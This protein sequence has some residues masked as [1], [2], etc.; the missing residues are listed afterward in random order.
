MSEVGTIGLVGSILAAVVSITVAWITSRL[1]AKVDI[2]DARAKDAETDLAEMKV[3]V[4][5]LRADLTRLSSV[6][7]VSI[8]Y[9]HELRATHP[10]PGSWPVDLYPYV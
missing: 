9:A 3:E 2:A 8:K 1:N 4:G 7:G 10:N 6:L 5:A